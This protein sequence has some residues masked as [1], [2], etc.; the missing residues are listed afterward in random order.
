MILPSPASYFRFTWKIRSPFSDVF[1][2]IEDWVFNINV[3]NMTFVNFFLFKRFFFSTGVICGI[4]NSVR[5]FHSLKNS[6]A[7]STIWTLIFFLWSKN[8]QCRILFE[9]I[10]KVS[11]VPEWLDNDFLSKKILKSI[12]IYRKISK[13]MSQ[14]TILQQ[15]IQVKL[16]MSISNNLNESL[17]LKSMCACSSNLL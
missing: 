1:D 7:L 10:D 5:Y 3:K 14:D 2:S 9:R 17:R 12:R 15:F 13:N 4:T 16:E 11:G 6:V 8:C